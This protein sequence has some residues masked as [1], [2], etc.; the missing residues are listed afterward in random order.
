MRC[1]HHHQLADP[2]TDHITS[3]Y[4][5]KA[6]LLK[7]TPYL[8]WQVSKHLS[9][10]KL[11]CLAQPPPDVTL[12]QLL[13]IVLSNIYKRVFL[14]VLLSLSDGTEKLAVT[15]QTSALLFSGSI[16]TCVS[17]QFKAPDMIMQLTRALPQASDMYETA[18][19]QIRLCHSLD[20][21]RPTTKR[22]KW[23]IERIVK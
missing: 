15:L 21:T 10:T 16:Y 14:I 4:Q 11:L 2:F 17:L 20:D 22:R 12:N 18:N 5:V 1:N 3:V 6:L 23:G 9:L 13:H 7:D 19:G 8:K